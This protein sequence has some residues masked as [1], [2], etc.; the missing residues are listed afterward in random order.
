MKNPPENQSLWI[1]GSKIISE[2]WSFLAAKTHGVRMRL[3]PPS[4][5]DHIWMVSYTIGSCHAAGQF[6]TAA[7][8]PGWA[9]PRMGQP[10]LP[11]L[12]ISID[13]LSYDHFL[14]CS[15]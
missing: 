9:C 2:A 6:Q 4:S 15:P 1:C 14:K 7:E 3:D 13:I 5:I 8:L 10:E 12:M 11:W